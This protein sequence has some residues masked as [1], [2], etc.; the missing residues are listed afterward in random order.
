MSE[1][2]TKTCPMCA[3]TIKAAAK[4]CP[5]CN[6]KQRRFEVWRQELPVS[7]TALLLLGIAILV[8]T[9]IAP[10]EKGVGRRNFTGHGDELVVTACSLDRVDGKTEFR[11]TGLL[12]NR[13]DHPW[14]VHELEVRFL[15]AQ[16]G[17][18]DVV[19]GGVADVFV[20]QPGH[21]HAFRAELRGVTFTNREITHLV[22]V[23]V[24]TDGNRTW[25]PD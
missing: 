9:W 18:L 2:E 10:D 22:R 21:D 23:Q 25:R 12:T 1:A 11:L 24:A 4:V 17:M 20:V 5:F 6:S 16:G 3:E 19:R 8:I 14:R 13:G 15:D 7:L